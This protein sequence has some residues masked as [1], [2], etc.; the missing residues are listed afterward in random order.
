MATEN[1]PAEVKPEVVAAPVEPVGPPDYEVARE[2]L[3][4]RLDELGIAVEVEFVPRS[5]SRDPKAKQVNWKVKVLH[6]C[7]FKTVKVDRYVNAFMGRREVEEAI[8]EGGRVLIEA[9]Y[10][11]GIGHIQGYKQNWSGR[12]NLEDGQAVDEVMEKG[13]SS[14][15]RGR[16]RAVKPTASDVVQCLLSD[17]SAID[18]A[19][20]EEWGPDLGYDK[21]SRKGEQVY[22]EC[23]ST[24]LKLRAAL[25]D[26]VLTELRELASRL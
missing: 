8:H 5:R 23:L 12:M 13:R 7:T 9:P 22:R 6:G 16:F 17:A 1:E 19:S 25:G 4:K 14:D 24:G 15:W 10:S 3:A 21:D 18:Y 26:A 11:T 20:Y 2:L